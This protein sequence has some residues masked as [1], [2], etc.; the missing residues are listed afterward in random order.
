MHRAHVSREITGR[1]YHVE[2]RPP[3]SMHF[4][5]RN[6]GGE[7]AKLSNEP[8]TEFPKTVIHGAVSRPRVA[9][10]LP[11]KGKDRVGERLVIRFFQGRP[12]AREILRGFALTTLSRAAPAVTTP[13]YFADLPPAFWENCKKRLFFLAPAH[14]DRAG[15]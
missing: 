11:I 13:A 9:I 15:V 4:S 12:N 14:G 7:I 10:A 1:E 6:V 2:M 8:A 3:V 5:S